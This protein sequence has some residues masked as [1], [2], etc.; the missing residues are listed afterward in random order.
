MKFK[1]SRSGVSL[2]LVAGLL[3]NIFVLTPSSLGASA[4][5]HE[6]L[7]YIASLNAKTSNKVLSGQQIGDAEKGLIGYKQFVERLYQKTGKWVAM[8]G[9]DYSYPDE[10]VPSTISLLNKRA[11]EYWKAGG[12]IT[13]S[14]HMGNPWGGDVRNRTNIGNYHD[15]VTPGNAAYDAWMSDLRKIADGLT[16]LR[17]NGVVVLWRPLHEMNGGWFWWPN[18]ST[19]FKLLWNH[20]FD[21]FTNTRKLDNLLWVFAASAD[22]TAAP[23]ASFFP[24]STKCDIVGLDYYGTTFDVSGYEDMIKLGKPF[25]LTEWGVNASGGDG[26]YDNINLINNIKSKLP[27]TSFFVVWSSWTGAK[28]AIVDNQNPSGL[29]N[30][31]WVISRDEIDR[32]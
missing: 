4:K 14:A 23:A 17:D 31:S 1:M 10:V 18:D 8:I 20:M 24:G 5:S 22:P 11:I 7:N 28:L 26:A 13:I 2:L 16:Q 9:I 27:A 6:I 30:D 29:M 25:G 21:Y 15:L 12:L 19:N 3:F 32:D